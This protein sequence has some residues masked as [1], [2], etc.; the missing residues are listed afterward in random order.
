VV[1]G[2]FMNGIQLV[3]HKAGGVAL[4]PGQ[5]S[6]YDESVPDLPAIAGAAG[7]GVVDRGR[8]VFITS[9]QP[10]M[11]LHNSIRQLNFRARWTTRQCGGNGQTGHERHCSPAANFRPRATNH[12]VRQPQSVWGSS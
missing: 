4:V 5:L 6:A 2:H 1:A 11:H 3:I 9:L 8:G 12:Q 10:A 7:T